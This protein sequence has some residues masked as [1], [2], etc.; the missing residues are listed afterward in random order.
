M[1]STGRYSYLYTGETEARNACP[2]LLGQVAP[3]PQL[4]FSSSDTSSVL[5]PKAIMAVGKVE[6]F[7]YLAVCCENHSASGCF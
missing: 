4:V 1:A 3:G 5:F 7:Q 6:L 2:G